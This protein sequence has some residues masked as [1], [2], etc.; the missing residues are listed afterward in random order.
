MKKA[1]GSRKRIAKLSGQFIRDGAVSYC[2][3]PYFNFYFS[4]LMEFDE[5]LIII[6]IMI[7]E[8]PALGQSEM[9]KNTKES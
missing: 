2:I 9:A 6:V 3:R 4:F 7:H 8:L 1:A 5:Y